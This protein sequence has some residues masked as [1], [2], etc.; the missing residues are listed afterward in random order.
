M[1]TKSKRGSVSKRRLGE[2][3]VAAGEVAAVEGVAGA[4]DVAKGEKNLKQARGAARVGTVAVAAAASDLTRAVDA[5]V[6]ADR[7]STLSDIVGTAGVVDMAEGAEMLSTSEDVEAMS[8]VVGLMSLSDL[9]RGLELGRLAGELWTISDVVD[10]MNMPVLS[11]VL[12]D[13]GQK[14]QGIAVDVI[15]RAAATRS[16]AH[17]MEATGQKI[18]ALGENEMDEGMLRMVAADVAKQRSEEL[19]EVSVDLE[20]RGAVEAFV[21]GAAN[22]SARQAAV[23][24]IGQVAEGAAEL[25]AAATTEGVAETLAEKAE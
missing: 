14:L 21:A 6:V 2:A 16:L 8:A 25:G 17:L 1:A 11:A 10:T 7:L 4:T 9:E 15:L 22:E 20:A 23:K 3:A 13:R 18:G 12:D 24:G 19:A 5:E